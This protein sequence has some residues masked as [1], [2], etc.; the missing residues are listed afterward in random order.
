MCHPMK[1]G[2]LVTCKE[3]VGGLLIQLGMIVRREQHPW[4]YEVLL[5]DGQ[6]VKECHYARMKV[7]Q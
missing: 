2:D 1:P 5:Q 7:I 3:Y 6:V 4:L